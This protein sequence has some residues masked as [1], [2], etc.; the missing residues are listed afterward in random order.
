MESPEPSSSSPKTKIFSSSALTKIWHYFLVFISFTLISHCGRKKTRFLK[1]C[2]HMYCV[3]YLRNLVLWHC[4][5]DVI[6]LQSFFKR[7][8][9]NDMESAAFFKIDVTKYQG[10]LES[11]LNIF[12]WPQGNMAMAATVSSSFLLRKSFYWVVW[13]CAHFGIWVTCVFTKIGRFREGK[14][15]VVM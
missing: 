13:N 4:V 6:H 5:S 7:S 15:E 12:P 14:S 9:R 11:L 8:E 10:G 1:R 3:A 2:I